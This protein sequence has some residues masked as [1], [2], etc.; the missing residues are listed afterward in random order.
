MNV[1]GRAE[2]LTTGVFPYE[3]DRSVA[4]L[5]RAGGSCPSFSIRCPK[6]LHSRS[7]ASSAGEFSEIP[8]NREVTRRMVCPFGT[9]ENG[10]ADDLPRELD[11]LT[12]I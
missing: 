12:L 9:T 3:T 2:D 4:S 5:G 7:G 6:R 10:R 11:P 8:S 1:T